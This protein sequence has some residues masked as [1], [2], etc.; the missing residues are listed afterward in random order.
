MPGKR[1]IEVVSYNMS[2]IRS[3]GTKLEAKLEEILK[4][5]PHEYARHPKIFGKPDF[6]YPELKIAVFADSDFW[7]GF[8]WETKKLEIK[9]NKQFWF[10]KIERNMARDME[11]T[12]KL[13][14][15]GW[16]VIRLWGHD[17]L[18]NTNK[19]R[20]II[21]EALNVAQRKLSNRAEAAG[22]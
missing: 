11:V 7:H 12:A 19:C 20:R 14:E 1:P 21:E 16:L 8:D 2:R 10:K 4:S 18:R 13:Q 22:V 9:S 5:I 15:E 3:E 6:A 17:I